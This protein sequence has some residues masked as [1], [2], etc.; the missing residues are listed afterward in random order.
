MMIGSFSYPLD[1]FFPF[2]APDGGEMTI[3]V[4]GAAEIEYAADGEEWR[5]AEIAISS[6]NGDAAIDASHP[7]WAPICN[8]L[9][10]RFAND[11]T[12]RIV[13]DLEEQHGIVFGHPNA[14]HRLGHLEFGL[15][16]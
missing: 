5:V 8:A 12:R 6:K 10:T 15:I 4:Y 14:E 7:L 3:V 2:M 11:I 1:E 16:R 13:H 9:R